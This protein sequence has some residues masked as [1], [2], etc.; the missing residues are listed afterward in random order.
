M[1][2]KNKAVDLSDF[3]FGPKHLDNQTLGASREIF[4][5]LDA[6]SQQI[7]G[8]ISR[9][10]F[11]SLWERTDCGESLK[12]LFAQYGLAIDKR[13]AKRAQIT[14]V[15]IPAVSGAYVQSEVQDVADM[16]NELK[17]KVNNMNKEA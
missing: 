17:A 11:Q 9:K 3:T 13:A 4:V 15:D 1:A 16:A 14:T 2:D 8:K 12:K 10:E 7:D 5:V 6:L